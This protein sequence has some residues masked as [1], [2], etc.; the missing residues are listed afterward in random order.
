MF[1]PTETGFYFEEFHYEW[2][3]WQRQYLWTLFLASRG[4]LKTTVLNIAD[5]VYDILR[6]F[7]LFKNY[8]IKIGIGSEV[9]GKAVAMLQQ[10]KRCFERPSFQTI[11]GN[12]RGEIWRED[13]LSFKGAK[14]QEKEANLT[15]FGGDSSAVASEHFDK[16]L[17][18]D[19]CT[20]ENTRTFESRQKM[21]A[22]LNF[23]VLPTLEPNSELKVL[24]LIGTRYDPNDLYGQE[25]KLQR[26]KIR[27]EKAILD[28]GTSFWE[29]KFPIEYLKKLQRQNP[30]IFAAQYQNDVELMRESKPLKSDWVVDFR[31]SELQ[32]FGLYRQIAIDPGGITEND[33]N[34]GCGISVIGVQSE[35]GRDFGNIYALESRC[36]F[37]DTWTLAK[38][39][40]DLW[41]Q[42]QKPLI[43]VEEVALQKVFQDVFK[44]EANRRG[45]IYFNCQGV[46]SSELKDK[47]T[48][49]RGITHFF[50][51]KQVHIDKQRHWELFSKLEDYPEV[52]TDDVNALLI[53]LYWLKN[54]WTATVEANRQSENKS[55]RSFKRSYVK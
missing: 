10:I 53:N 32:N 36:I 48:L 23:D 47:I 4:S 31:L 41:E 3:R 38:R 24:R 22:R 14:L 28:D 15:A 13:K 44:Q 27:R 40:V 21:N 30:V 17:L 35:K 29:K 39:V 54:Y 18:D 51:Q 45:H 5:N 49:A 9:R 8:S 16:L 26:L 46:K 34:S 2:Q 20:F 50:T 7:L 6:D 43:L 1:P 25:I 33:E 42:Y 37:E 52:G 55:I 12:L 11:Y 19:F